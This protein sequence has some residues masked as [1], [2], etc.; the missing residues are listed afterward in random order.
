MNRP[1]LTIRNTSAADIDALVVL[2]ELIYGQVYGYSKE[3]MQAHL[4]HFPQGQFVAVYGDKVVGFCATFR[5]AEK[6]ALAPHT[7]V[8]ITGDGYAARHDAH[9]D[10]LYGMEM[11]VDPSYRNL[12]IGKRLLNARKK[13]CLSLGLSAI[14][15]GGRLPSLHRKI[16][17]YGSVESF[18]DAVLASK[19]TDPTLS[20]Q[21]RNGFE[22]L[23]PLPN[24]LTYD[25]ESLG[26][27][28]HLIWRNT[29]IAENPVIRE[30][31]R[32]GRFND[33]VRIAVIQY[34]QRRVISFDEF[35]S[36]VEYFIDV[37]SDYR[38]DFAVLPEMF[39]MQLLSMPG[40]EQGVEEAL[41]DLTAH[42]PAIREMLSRLAVSYNVNIIG[43]SHIWTDSDGRVRNSCMVCLRDGSMHERDKIH[44]TPSEQS[45]WG[46][47][48]G[49][50]AE[51][52]LTD[53]GPIGIMVCYD[54]EFPELG[55]HL[56]DQGAML[57][58]V[59]FCTDTRAA[60]LR[61]RY[62]CQARAV[63]NQ[64]Y[65]AMA[66]N[67]GNLPSVEN[68]DIQYAQSCI[69]TPCDFLFSRD[70]IAAD[71]TPNTEMV[72]FA[73]LRFDDLIRARNE[74]SVMNLRDRRFDLYSTKW[75]RR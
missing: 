11:C 50:S 6:I 46:V 33:S 43:G 40:V 4:L 24:Y 29:E 70:G 13:L 41:A 49:N 67:V 36:N 61:V 3:M 28:A 26:Y 35:A 59:P 17:K 9:G 22:L 74:G 44:I 68:M 60:Y 1:K 23:G 31:A 2:S 55:R 42:T 69:L 73:D 65:V 15:F 5:I 62:S 10:V 19:E 53:C 18:M 71:T 20:F 34:Q 14:V 66:G 64:C 47:S 32:D 52:I 56:V 45:F 38:A 7:W 51:I 12:R 48:G 37:V 30:A 39:T 72:A 27:G 57:L 58:I 63:E 16:K 54:S 8:E 25:H 21:L 75:R